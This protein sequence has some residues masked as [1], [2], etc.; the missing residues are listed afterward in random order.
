[1]GRDTIGFTELFGGLNEGRIESIYHEVYPPKTF[2]V[3]LSAQMLTLV[4]FFLNFY[5]LSYLWFSTLF[6][7]IVQFLCS[8]IVFSHF[9]TGLCLS[10]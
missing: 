8:S 4:L 1:M 2:S 7:D 5:V 6:W 10:I 3:I 9:S